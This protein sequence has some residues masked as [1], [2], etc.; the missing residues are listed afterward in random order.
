[1]LFIWLELVESEK[2]SDWD[3]LN[4]CRAYKQIQLTK[5]KQ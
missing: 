4:S 2:V 1:M 5:T 3:I